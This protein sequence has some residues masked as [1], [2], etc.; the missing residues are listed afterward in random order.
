MIVSVCHQSV[1]SFTEGALSPRS[2]ESTVQRRDRL[3]DLTVKG[4][5]PY[6]QSSVKVTTHSRFLHSVFDPSVSQP[7]VS[8]HWVG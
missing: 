7:N 8:Q 3:V 4:I 6:V 2:S 5:M 1:T